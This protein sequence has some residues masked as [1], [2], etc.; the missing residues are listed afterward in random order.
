MAVP[1]FECLFRQGFEDQY[2]IFRLGIR[3]FISLGLNFKQILD[4]N[5]QCKELLHQETFNIMFKF[6]NHSSLSAKLFLIIFTIVN[7]IIH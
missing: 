5:V 1:N 4:N 2:N 3:I 7:N 6:I